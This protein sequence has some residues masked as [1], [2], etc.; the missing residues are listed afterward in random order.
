[1]PYPYQIDYHNPD[2]NAV[3]QWRV[4]RLAELRADPGLLAYIKSYYREHPIE[5]VQD[6]GVT[7]DPRMPEIG[8]SAVL[9][10]IPFPEQVEWM[11]WVL[12]LWRERE[13]GL[14]DK[15]RDMG[16]TWCAASLS[17]ALAL[18]HNGFVAGFGSRKED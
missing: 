16:L 12:D 8:R 18:S 1:M 15:S 4:D 5:L 9:P 14:S 2:Y 10:F 7:F 17:G 13:N 11:Q 6:W 3:W